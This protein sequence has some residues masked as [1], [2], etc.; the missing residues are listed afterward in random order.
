MKKYGKV[1]VAITL[2]LSMMLNGGLLTFAQEATPVA[3]FEDNLAEAIV[4][5]ATETTAVEAAAETEAVTNAKAISALKA[6]NNQP[7][8]EINQGFSIHTGVNDGNETYMNDFVAKKKTAVMMKIPGSDDVDEAKAK[9]I[10]KDY[11]LSVRAVTNGQVSD[12]EELKADASNFNVM[13]AYDQDNDITKGYY[14]VVNFPEGPD[15]GTYQFEITN[16]NETVSKNEGVNFYETQPLNILV[17]PVNGYWSKATYDA[18]NAKYGSKQVG[19]ADCSTEKYV[20]L[21][22]TEKEWSSLCA[23]LK[24]Y[25]LDVYPLTTINIEEGKKVEA[26]TEEYDMV[27]SDGQKKLWEE[28]C[29]LQTK[30]K[31]TGKDKY[32]IILAFVMYRQDGGNGQ[33]YTYGKPTNIITYIDPDMFPT[34]AH[35]I[36]HCYKVGDE[37][38]GGSLYY[39]ADGAANLPPNGYKG[40]DYATGE[41]KKDTE[42]TAANAYWKSPKQYKAEKNNS[43]LDEN[44]AGTMVYGSLHPYSLSKEKFISWAKT[45]DGDG[46]TF[47]TISYMGSGYSGNDGYYFSSSV[48][49]DYL[50]KQFLVKE[51]KQEEQQSSEAENQ[52]EEVSN[53]DVF[54]NSLRSAEA[55]F[56]SVSGNTVDEDDFYFDDNYREGESRMVEVS[57]WFIQNGSDVNIEMDPMFS[58]EGDLSYMETEEVPDK[59]A[60]TF[61]AVD[62]DGNIITSPVDNELAVTVFNGNTYNPAMQDKIESGSI[63][64]NEISI[65]FDSEYPYGTADLVIFKG[66]VA[67][68]KT[69]IKDYSVKWSAKDTGVYFFD[70]DT[71]SKVNLEKE[72]EAVLEY[73]EVNNQNAVVEWN[74]YYDSDVP[75]DGKSGALYT[76]V[77]YCPQGDEGEI[78]YVT[79][80]TDPEWE[81]GYVSIDTSNSEAGY[82][83]SDKAYVWIKVTNGVNAWD[84]YSDENEVSLS[85]GNNEITL[86]GSGMKSQTVTVNGKKEKKYFAEYVG[87][88]ITPKV[89][90]K[91]YDPETEKK[92]TLTQDVDFKV[93]Y[94]DNVNAGTATVIIEGIGLYGGRCTKEFT[95]NKKKLAGNPD[96]L[97]D[98]ILGGDLEKEISKSLSMVDNKQNILVYNKDFTVRYSTN[99]GAK[100]FQNKV[101]LNG[102]V[103]KAFADRPSASKVTIYVQYYG[104]G[105]YDATNP[106]SKKMSFD[107]YKEGLNLE[108]AVVELKK[109]SVQYNGK[110]QKVG[111]KSVTVSGNVIKPNQYKVVYYNNKNIGTAKVYVVG[112]K[113]AV[114]RSVKAATFK[115]TQKEV[116]NL[117]ITKVKDQPYTGK[118]ISAN[119]LPLTVKAGGILLTKGVD[120][121]V[122]YVSGDTISGN[123]INTDKANIPAFKV[124]LKTDK[125]PVK[126]TGP[127]AKWKNVFSVKIVPAKLTA[128]AVK[129]KVSGNN[130]VLN[131][132]DKLKIS[133]NAILT[134]HKKAKGEKSSYAFDIKGTEEY[135][136]E[137]SDVSNGIIATVGDLN[138]DYSDTNLYNV[139]ITKTK[140][141]GLNGKGGIGKITI[142]PTRNNKLFKGK[143]EIKFLYTK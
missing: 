131:K 31:E 122:E 108:N 97:P 39:A 129:A 115:I 81:E 23:E 130:I 13:Q 29:K 10:I 75:Y 67:E 42:T 101:S 1:G 20:G 73:A 91:A 141:Q 15:K 7:Q 62:K 74:T 33:G 100:Y 22:G 14:L 41:S 104:K 96:E 78:Y 106:L 117:S 34:V 43:K 30:D 17:V 89:S 103:E 47:P 35:E 111:V 36:A 68:G 140:A 16:G 58:Y 136:Y 143:R 80:S 120:Y 87:T 53:L 124:V 21:D 110:T 123:M 66:K 57:A 32:D 61:A 121:T 18:E 40:T 59:F 94:K 11:K 132:S 63:S 98:L 9:E 126:L 6:D 109:D 8:I 128:A 99:K 65:K 85:N 54:H 19:A 50:Y 25:L 88:A 114:G 95:I 28:V 24:T 90:V 70:K 86:S 135:F 116:K 133:S 51:K 48:I 139:K 69:N 127:E 112:K 138:I 27:G 56:T 118:A 77:Y 93:S 44:G 60:Y 49:W 5:E 52:T 64:V 84:L 113:G 137:N 125:A 3:V 119:D 26:G 46:Q 55:R 79:D 134:L 76:E 92:I 12:N 72:P 71:A 102:L 82:G 45:G 37:Y 4:T 107:V 105:N 83:Y 142:T 38:D 2:A